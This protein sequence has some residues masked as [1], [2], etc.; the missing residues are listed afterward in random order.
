MARPG[1]HRPGAVRGADLTDAA[2][3]LARILP[4]TVIGV[5]GCADEPLWPEEEALV[6]NAV[7]KRRREVA[8]GRACARRALALLGAPV[9]ALPADA[10]R[11]PR[12][13]AEVAG[14]I[15]HALDYVAAA[16]AWQR[17]HR[18][19]GIDAELLGRVEPGLEHLIAT[20]GERDWLAAHP[21]PRRDELRTLLFSAKEAA[22]KAQ[23]PLTREMVDFLDASVV[24]WEAQGAFEVTFH[25]RALHALPPVPGRFA[26]GAGRIVTLATL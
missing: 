7:P 18:S 5:E 22:F 15:T 1:E 3:A 16:V 21:E 11:V 12:W 24:V 19:L 9:C 8:A 2:G 23:F 6:A 14:S 25:A 4:A 10:D 17:D 26:I 20:A 13:P